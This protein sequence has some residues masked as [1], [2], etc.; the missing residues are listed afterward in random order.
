MSIIRY[1][2][3][4]DIMKTVGIIVE[5]NPLHNGHVYHIEETKR[6]SKADRVI[7]VMSG[8]F[9]QRGEPAII[10]KFT[11]TKWALNSG[12]DLVV[13]LP[14]VFTVQNADIFAYTSVGILDKLSV[15]EIYFGSETGNIEELTQIGTI[16]ESDEYNTLVKRYMKEGTSYPTS[17]DKAMKELYPNNSFDLPNNILGI[18]YILAGRKLQSNIVFKTIQ[19]ISTNYFDNELVGSSIQSATSIRSLVTKNEDI[20]KYVPLDVSNSLTSRKLVTY[21]DFYNQIFPYIFSQD[22]Q[23]ENWKELIIYSEDFDLRMNT[24]YAWVKEKGYKGVAPVLKEIIF[25]ATYKDVVSCALRMMMDNND[26]EGLFLIWDRAL[27]ENKEYIEKVCVQYLKDINLRQENARRFA[28]ESSKSEGYIPYAFQ[29]YRKIG[30]VFGL[31]GIA[32]DAMFSRRADLHYTDRGIDP[33]DLENIDPF[34]ARKT[35][36]I[37][38]DQGVILDSTLARIS[39]AISES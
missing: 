1:N 5:Y 28:N 31:W 16:L 12:V 19:R 36:N 25:T 11:R 15:D 37:G 3:I 30:R 35:G 23:M 8:N 17:S 13:E 9:T 27:R 24:L 14:F 10:D 6:L 29:W 20:S 33:Y 38:K 21:E 22:R 39:S 34:L 7:C 18:Q 2:L 4:G 26:C 32:N